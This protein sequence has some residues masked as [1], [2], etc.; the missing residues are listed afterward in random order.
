MA[1]SG[2]SQLAALFEELYRELLERR[3]AVAEAAFEMGGDPQRGAAQAA[4][5]WQALLTKL[6]QQALEVRRTSG[7]FTAELHREA[8]YVMA[9]LADEI[10]LN[11][12]WAGRAGWQ[13]QLLESK[14]FGT[15]RAGD[16][17]FARLDR[18]LQNQDPAFRSLGEV[19]L[20]ALGLGFQGRYRG[21]PDADQAIG[22]YR[23]RLYRYLAE[24]EPVV[25]AGKQRL[26][27]AAYG[28]TL[29]QATLTRLPHSRRVLWFLLIG[30]AA[31]VLLSWPVWNRLTGELEPTLDEILALP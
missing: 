2:A 28:A 20:A 17:V 24:R 26:A 27:A 19:Y 16:E 9:A 18:L 21:R 7:D 14:L 13:A 11:L 15:H 10:F 5:V 31:W 25:F 29:S 22:A 4:T 12:D 3:R 30:I 8:Q 1:S 23:L 6:E